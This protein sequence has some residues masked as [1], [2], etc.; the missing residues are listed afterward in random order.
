VIDA[1]FIKQLKAQLAERMQNNIN[2]KLFSRNQITIEASV[3]PELLGDGRSTAE[4]LPEPD[5]ASSSQPAES[6][7][8]ALVVIPN[9]IST[10]VAWDLQGSRTHIEFV[11]LNDSNELLAIRNVVLLVDSNPTP[12][13]LYFKQFVDVKVDARLPSEV[14]LPIVVRTK[15]GTHLCAELQG[16]IDVKFGSIDRECALVVELN[17]RNVSCRFTAQG[18]SMTGAILEELAKDAKR[19][20]VAVALAL[21]ISLMP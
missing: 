11:F 10:I 8:A 13:A 4:A 5:H 20:K 17:D 15:S 16:S 18:G 14:R 12:D 2:I 7:P 3:P 19:R 1:G 9:S 21:P 6:H